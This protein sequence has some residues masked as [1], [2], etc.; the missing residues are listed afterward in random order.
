[1][2]LSDSGHRKTYERIVNRK[3]R[4]QRAAF[5]GIILDVLRPGIGMMEIPRSERLLSYLQVARQNI[6]ILRPGIGVRWIPH[7]GLEL[8]QQNGIATIRLE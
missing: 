5:H 1:M 2:I 8:A 3:H 7:S 6:K 4:E